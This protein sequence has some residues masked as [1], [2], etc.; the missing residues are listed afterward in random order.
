[1]AYQ[2]KYEQAADAYKEY[3]GLSDDVCQ[4]YE[5][6]HVPVFTQ[7]GVGPLQGGNVR[8]WWSLM[9]VMVKY[10]G[11]GTVLG[12]NLQPL[13]GCFMARVY[14]GHVPWG[15]LSGF[16]QQPVGCADYSGD[17]LIHSVYGMHLPW[18]V[19]LIGPRLSSN[20]IGWT[21][22]LLVCTRQS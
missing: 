8:H 2:D 10:A 14:P 19:T 22:G 5:G 11:C 20:G 21:L 17:Q 6:T 7:R 13:L 3:G 9:A 16:H 4:Y 1:M 18:P 15:V 12:A